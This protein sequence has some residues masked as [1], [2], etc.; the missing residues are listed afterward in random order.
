MNPDPLVLTAAVLVVS[1]LYASVGHGGASGY[2]AVLTLLGV[3]GPKAAGSALAL[4]VLVAG[5]AW[6]SFWRAGHFS[7]KQ[8]APLAACSIPA[9]ALGG[10]LD[11]SPALF[12]VLLAVA[13]AWAAVRMFMPD[14][15]A[16]EL[17]EPVV[18]ALAAAG[19]AIGL[20]SGIVGVGGGIFLS[21]LMILMRWGDVKRVAAVS[22]AFIVVNS[23]AGLA[24]RAVRGSLEILPYAAPVA[25]AFAGGLL[26]GWLGSRKLGPRRLRALLGV[27]LG[28]A[29]L[30][31]FL[32]R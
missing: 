22:A 15:K 3:V 26:G 28:L 8:I 13:L 23:A 1:A 21:P 29:S 7:W 16:A 12:R 4:N 25:A 5:L 19:G 30:K 20:L 11:V 18:P 10:W 31:L 32:V 14:P 6:I 17:R 9:A 24:G 27:V 2:L